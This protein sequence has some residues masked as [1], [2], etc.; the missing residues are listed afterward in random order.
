MS[1]SQSASRTSGAH[2]D[3]WAKGEKLLL[4]L[5]YTGV[6]WC[7]IH[8]L[9][10]HVADLVVGV[11]FEVGVCASPP[12]APG[13]AWRWSSCS[14]EL[15]HFPRPL[16]LWRGDQ[17]TGRQPMW[18]EDARTAGLVRYTE[19]LLSLRLHPSLVWTSRTQ[20]AAGHLRHKAPLRLLG[21]P[22][23]GGEHCGFSDT[24]AGCDGTER[25]CGSLLFSLCDSDC[26]GS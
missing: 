12:A 8:R 5:R 7:Q 6:G 22:P 3:P 14:M 18:V 23:Q 1:A 15:S 9:G 2:Q 20:R 11:G 10:H 24:L 17:Q 21:R 19:F 26:Y 13:Q 25:E 4:R 16:W